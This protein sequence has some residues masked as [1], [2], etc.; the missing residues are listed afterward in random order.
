MGWSGSISGAMTEAVEPQ[1]HIRFSASCGMNVYQC[2]SS[3]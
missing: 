1:P 3:I 2:V